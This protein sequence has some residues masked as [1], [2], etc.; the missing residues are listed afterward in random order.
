M[1]C[2][3]NLY[4][5]QNACRSSTLSKVLTARL[6]A[7]TASACF[8]VA[9]T[10][11]PTAATAADS[12]AVGV[13]GDAAGLGKDVEK[14]LGQDVETELGKDVETD[15]G[16]DV[17]TGQ[18]DASGPAD[19]PS[20]SGPDS[21]GVP[22]DVWPTDAKP[23]DVATPAAQTAGVCFAELPPPGTYTGAQP[24]PTA[25]CPELGTPEWY[26]DQPV[27]APTLTVQLGRRDGAGL[28]SPLQD[29]DWVALETALQG[30]FHLE[31]IPKILLPGKTEPKVQLQA[32][33]F[34]AAEC[35]PVASL[36]LAKSW[37]VRMP[38]PQPWYTF[39][40][41]AKPLIIFGVSVAKKA[42]FCGLWLKVHWRL[43][44]LG[45]T[46]WGEAVHTLRTYDGTKLP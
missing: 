1:R 3:A 4:G 45:A 43:R 38:G 27:P 11:A 15:L 41:T 36:N 33:A 42:Q 20:D 37:L 23:T 24:M 26:V 32:E 5:R 10:T 40:A 12:T 14:G 34:A 28:W 31:L 29:G 7:V 46:Q 39:E 16:K 9:C 35:N 2:P 21:D 8:G 25:P 19:T 17:E 18:G 22:A 6:W 30:G 13:D 44:L